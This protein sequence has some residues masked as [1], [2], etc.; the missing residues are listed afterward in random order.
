MARPRTF[1]QQQVLDQAMDVF[2]RHG[3]DGASFAELTKAMNLNAPSIYAA[4]GS[5]RGL[6]DA[7]LQR[8]QQRR[9]AHRESV[10]AAPT[11]RAAAERML[12]GAIDWLTDPA[13]PAGCLLF[14]SGLA[15][16][17]TAPDIPPL[18]V[19]RRANILKLLTERFTR[20]Q[21][22]GDL[23]ASADPAALARYIQTVFSGLAIQA[24]AG[25]AKLDLQ[26]D[27]AQALRGWPG[28][29]GE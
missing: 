10:S 15:C 1:D 13:E 28:D 20:A 9:A 25:V 8:Y 19:Q 23:P 7:V 12:F 29:G 11:A 6:F 27:A 21:A 17:T 4:F 18:L 26:A 22:E 5:K 2:W 3:Y 14:Q 24:A 16:S